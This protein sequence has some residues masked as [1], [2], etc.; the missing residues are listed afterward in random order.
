MTKFKAILVSEDADKLSVRTFYG[1][2][3]NL[4]TFNKIYQLMIEDSL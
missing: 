4:D 3:I 2:E 1:K